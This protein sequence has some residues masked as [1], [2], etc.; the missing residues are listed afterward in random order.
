MMAVSTEDWLTFWAL[1]A[2]GFIL[3]MMDGRRP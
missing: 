2:A 3:S 1:L